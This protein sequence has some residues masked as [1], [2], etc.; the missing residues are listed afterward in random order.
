[1]AD[2]AELREIADWQRGRI[3]PAILFDDELYRKERE[4]VFG[5][6]WLVVGHEDMVRKPGDYVTNYMGEVPVIVLRDGQAKIRVLVNR[7][8]H[9]GN[10]VCL[11]DR[12]NTRSF[13]CSYHGW[14]YDLAGK[15]TGVPMERELYR[16]EL[17]KSAW[18]LEEVSR[19]ESFGG[20]LFASFDANAPALDEWL[21]DDVR[22]WLRNFVL[23]EP[24]GGLEALPGWH[25]YR[26][27]GNWKLISENF[28]GDDYHVYAA[29]HVS[30]FKVARDF[31]EKGMLIPMVTYPGDPGGPAFEATAGYGRGCPFGL[32]IVVLHDAVYKRDLEEARQLGAEAV[33]WVQHRFAR[34]QAVLHDREQKPYSFMNGLLFP[35]L[36][37]MGFL[38][39][40]LGRQFLLF[41]PRGVWDHEVWQWTMVEREAPKAV[42]ELAVQRAY[43]GQHMGGIIAPDDVENFERLVE[44]MRTPRSWRRPFHYGMQLGHE[45]EAPAGLPGRLGPNPSEVNQRQFYRFWLELMERDEQ[46]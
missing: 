42:K 27:P 41:Q 7:C 17:N 23:A 5:R 20:L 21:G 40:M 26:S 14:T 3:S 35:N 22:W 33:E 46:S 37:L 4:R 12:G 44:A 30:W 36:G 24:L 45:E 34:L 25:R 15:L 1:M 38:S 31:A 13:S 39:P 9:R 10:Q 29:T 19:V 28:S 43:Q 2:Q 6:A 8:A 11:F 32:G 16:G 18:G